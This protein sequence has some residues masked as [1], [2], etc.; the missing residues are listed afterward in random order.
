MKDHLRTLKTATWLGWQIESN[1]A[2]PWL[3]ALYVLIKP[4]T[5]SLL[6]IF[7]YKAARWA[8]QD[9]VSESYLPFLYVGNACYML[10]GAVSFGLTWVVISDREHYGMLKFI[11]MSPA[12][13]Q[14]Y[15]VG[16]G[17]ARALE[18]FLGA[19]LTIAIGLVVFPELASALTRPRPWTDWLW[20]AYYLV[21]GTVMLITIGLILAGAVLN[22]ARHGMF[23]SEGIAGVI[24]LLCGAVFPVHIL[25][26]PLPYISL[27]LP[28]TY[29]LEGMRRSLLGGQYELGSAL[30][31]WDHGHLSLALLASTVA[32]GV[33]ARFF[34]RWCE[35]RAW[36]KGKF[37]EQTGM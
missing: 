22:M 29:W 20:L 26:Q 16:R 4:F 10:V 25:P 19:C 28:M 8:T 13:F 24:Y 17:V 31:G 30:A 27:G 34:F 36:Q 3:F 32:L 18:S 33:F 1:W 23:L 37:D 5:G 9:A 6:L 35:R 21:V 7:M 15:L 12:R 11:Y 2:D 14:T